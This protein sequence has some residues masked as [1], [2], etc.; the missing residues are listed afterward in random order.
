MISLEVPGKLTLLIFLTF[1]GPCNMA[2]RGESAPSDI[3]KNTN[4]ALRGHTSTDNEDILHLDPDEQDTLNRCPSESLLNS[5][6]DTKGKGTDDTRITDPSEDSSDSDSEE[7][8]ETDKLVTK[9]VK[10]AIDKYVKAL[11]KE[12]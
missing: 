4:S 7:K 9:K 8:S 1:T 10:A 12:R 6:N 2:S 3:R 11:G 5:D